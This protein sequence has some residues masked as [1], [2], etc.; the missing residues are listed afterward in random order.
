MGLSRPVKAQCLTTAADVAD[1]F[2]GVAGYQGVVGDVFGYYSASTNQGVAAYGV[3]A[4]DGGVGTDCGS[5]FYQG[6][7]ILGFAFN[8]AAGVDDVGED[9]GW[10]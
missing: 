5:F 2:A 1:D 8:E 9:A 10:S 3:T 4:D 7:F 6:S